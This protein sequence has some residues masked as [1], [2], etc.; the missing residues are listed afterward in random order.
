[1]TRKRASVLK[2]RSMTRVRVDDELGIRDVLA[3]SERV[4]C[5]NHDVVI[6]VCDQHWLHDLL[7]IS[8]GLAAGLLPSRHRRELGARCLGGGWNVLIRC[9]LRKP[10]HELAPSG[11]AS[12]CGCKK[13][14]Q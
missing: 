1:M 11:L 14:L 13:K 12:L 4:D 5:G 6:P 9:A 7:Q 10:F 2:Q 8:V 3:E